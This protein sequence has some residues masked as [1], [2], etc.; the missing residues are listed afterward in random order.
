MIKEAYKSGERK[1]K[2]GRYIAKL[3]GVSRNRKTI[4]SIL[5]SISTITKKCNSSVNKDS[6]CLISIK[7]GALAP[8]YF[9]SFL[10][11]PEHSYF[12]LQVKNITIPINQIEPKISRD[13]MYYI[14]ST[15]N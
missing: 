14:D 1:E 9:E 15:T 12:S 4:K 5:D 11:Y 7:R 13:T 8:D 2:V 6:L 3:E 10:K